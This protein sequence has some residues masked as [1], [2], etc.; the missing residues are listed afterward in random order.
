MAINTYT[1]P[2]RTYTSK[3]YDSRDP[4]SY[5]FD[6][7]VINKQKAN[8]AAA[9]KEAAYNKMGALYDND[10]ANDANAIAPT[11]R[12]TPT[13]VDD[14]TSTDTA[15]NYGKYDY[16]PM[17]EENPTDLNEEEP[18]YEA[19]SPEYN[20]ALNGETEDNEAD[21]RG[22]K[23][24]STQM[25]TADSAPVSGSYAADSKATSRSSQPQIPQVEIQGNGNEDQYNDYGAQNTEQP[26]SVRPAVGSDQAQAQQGIEDPVNSVTPT[27]ENKDKTE[28]DA[29]VV[30]STVNAL[31]DNRSPNEVDVEYMENNP[32]ALDYLIKYVVSNFEEEDAN[33]L[34]QKIRDTIMDRNKRTPE[35]QE[36]KE[37]S[38]F[39]DSSLYEVD[40]D[41][42]E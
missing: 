7:D 42:Y 36:E 32:K 27:D 6:S 8:Q 4:A 16:A 31:L 30:D 34:L 17:A 19:F 22:Y 24:D 15:P 25:G 28:Q 37:Q 33:V 21:T 29:M 41:D 23:Y 2:N 11:S 26:M 13:P 12:N 20:Q 35:T 1:K 18:N 9:S 38:Y 39:A 40:D 5:M 10:Y 14:M 3:Q